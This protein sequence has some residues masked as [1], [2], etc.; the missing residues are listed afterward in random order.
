M[1][2]WGYSGVLLR[3]WGFYVVVMGVGEVVLCGLVGE[4]GVV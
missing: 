3:V 1:I 4:G 2:V